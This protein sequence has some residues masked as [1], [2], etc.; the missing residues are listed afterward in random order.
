MYRK[1][2]SSAMQEQLPRSGS[3]VEGA[4]ASLVI[5]AQAGMTA[6]S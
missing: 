4:E 1:Y 2:G 3:F 5:P 6:L